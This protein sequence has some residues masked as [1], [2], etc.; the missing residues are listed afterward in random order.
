MSSGA[1]RWA[2]P[3]AWAGLGVGLVVGGCGGGV[4]I[5]VGRGRFPAGFAVVVGGIW[6][7]L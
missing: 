7:Q 6:I 4:F 3:G 1:W 2:S 5:G